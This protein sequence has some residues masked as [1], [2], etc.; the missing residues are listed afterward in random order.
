MKLAVLGIERR[1][2]YILDKSCI[3][4]LYFQLSFLFLFLDNVSLCCTDW[5]GTFGHPNS[6]KIKSKIPYIGHYNFQM[7]GMCSLVL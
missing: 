7:L 3:I 6:A 5:P 4:E 2:L 1:G